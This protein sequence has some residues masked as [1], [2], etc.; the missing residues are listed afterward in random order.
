MF[1]KVI[2]MNDFMELNK[3]NIRCVEH[4]LAFAWKNLFTLVDSECYKNDFYIH[5]TLSLRV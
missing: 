5:I 3:T 4:T 1:E 2:K